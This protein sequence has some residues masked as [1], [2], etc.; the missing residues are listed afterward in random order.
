[1]NELLGVS[2]AQH[3]DRS[4]PSM[5]DL[6]VQ[7]PS[8]PAAAVEITAAADAE[9][10]EFWAQM[11]A[12]RWIESRLAGGW[13]V[14]VAPGSSFKALRRDL[15]T[16]LGVFEQAGVR[17]FNS[18]YRQSVPGEAFARALGVTWAFQSPTTSYPGSIYVQPE[19]P[20]ERASGYVAP[21]GDALAEWLSEFLRTSPQAQRV[22][23]KLRLS[24]AAETHAF[25]LVPG[26]VAEAPFPVLDL[27]MFDDRPLP[28]I[29]PQLPAEIT[30]VW[31]ATPG[32]TGSVYRWSAST[33]WLR[34]RKPPPAEP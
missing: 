2:V 18:R 21:T 24:R 5:H 33:G 30:D 4:R 22:R 15:P 31:A 14:H 23:Q 17:R 29:A 20:Q 26:L 32:A 16:L 7:Y 8:R 12:G 1:M 10:I 27:V 25:V 9:M 34:F 3:D 19:L 28:T 13:A 11:D 6:S